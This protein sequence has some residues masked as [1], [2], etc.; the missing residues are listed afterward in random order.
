MRK[1]ISILL[2]A[3]IIPLFVATSCREYEEASVD[4]Y[5]ILTKYMKDT[6][7]DFA[8][9]VDA[10]WVKPANAINVNVTDYSVPDYYV[11]DIRSAVDFDNGHIKGAVNVALANILTAAPNAGTKPILVVCYTGQ[12]AARAVA[13]L[14]LSGYTAHVL[15]WGMAGWNSAFQAKW[16]SNAAQLNH[17][18]WVTTGAPAA[19]SQFKSPVLTT[20]KTTG[21][22]ILQ[23][24]IAIALANTV[25][26]VSKTDVLANP[27]NYFIN[28]K[29]AQA[30]WDTYG[31]ITSAYRI[32]V[33]DGLTIDG[34]NKFNPAATTLVT[35]CYTG[36]T[37]SITTAWLN[38]VGFDNAKSL[39]FGANGII[40]DNMKNGSVAIRKST[41]Q[42]DLSAWNNNFGYYKT[43]GTYV[44]P[45]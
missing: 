6:G 33:A 2:I 20:G 14:R 34:L 27:T 41:W 4:E 15:K 36:Q 5:A 26:T 39:S 22:E 18:N 10:T 16:T 30:D 25:W 40:W 8:N 23:A 1:R 31:H 12:T 43:D 38:V 19:V 3:V 13:F 32:D 45:L 11:M 44:A 29:W 7:K 9:V 37:S 35:Y 28:N 17:T 42:G 21:A 24:R